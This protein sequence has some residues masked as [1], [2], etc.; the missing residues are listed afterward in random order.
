MA[1]WSAA[2]VLV[3]LAFGLLE[4]EHYARR[5]RWTD[6]GLGAMDWAGLCAAILGKSLW[7][8]GPV[9]GVAWG[10][11]RAAR[12]RAAW[13]VV[14]GGV[15]SLCAVLFID[16]RLADVTGVGL[17]EYS[18]YARD[19]GAL[20]M[21][22]QQRVL[23]AAAKAGGLAAL[24]AAVTMLAARRAL[25]R[26]GGPRP[27][28][29]R[30]LW[31]L[32]ASLLVGTSVLPAAVRRPLL[33]ARLQD[34]LVLP[35]P[36]LPPLVEPAPGNDLLVALQAELAAWLPR[37]AGRL[38]RASPVRDDLTLGA[39]RPDVLIV[40]VESM[41]ADALDP[42]TM[43]RLARWAEEHARRFDRHRSGG[44][45]SHVGVFTTL[46]G[47]SGLG[48]SATLEARRP[49][50]LTHT[51]GRAGYERY[52]VGGSA[53]EWQG[54]DRFVSTLNFD[55]VELD[56]EGSWPERDRRVVARARELLAGSG[57]RP[58]RL[59]YAFLMSTHF[60]YP[61]PAEYERF[62]PVAGAGTLGFE[63]LWSVRD[64]SAEFVA[65]WRNRYRNCL[66][67]V[68]A[69]L[70]DLL[71]G[72]DLER[73]VVV[74]TG[75]HG[76]SFHEDGAWLHTGRFS[77]V[78]IATEL[79]LAGRGVAPGRV[80]AP[81]SHVDVAPT[82]LELVAG[83][84]LELGELHGRSLLRPGP[85]RPTSAVGPQTRELVLYPRGDEPARL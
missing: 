43:P 48:Y 42:Q 12:P 83:R 27:A 68:D 13:A 62:R 69:L 22:G 21:M 67:W 18:R 70:D 36:S 20:E 73:T 10:L 23:G 6:A 19:A 41:R 38:R 28:R 76:E 77:D 24:T 59:V 1:A 64:P 2:C 84:P 4:L 35:V 34:A 30:V 52:F 39:A 74:I 33:L 61:Y 32:I 51:L 65:G 80:S 29:Q 75:D 71:T 78:Q 47:R 40:Q 56:R 66:G 55:A 54:M 5:F 8:V 60:D 45:S 53:I 58:P 50:L 85:P 15:A 37:Y 14:C 72:L 11:L 44:N 79:L 82:V 57:A 9:L 7:L 26:G 63:E 81:S 17:W 3:L 49:A 31:A 16:L 25:E 46:Y